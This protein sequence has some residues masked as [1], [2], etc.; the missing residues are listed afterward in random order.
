MSKL[1]GNMRLSRESVHFR[2]LGWS[3]Q[4]PWSRLSPTKKRTSF[5]PSFI[6][7]IQTRSDHASDHLLSDQLV[8]SVQPSLPDTQLISEDNRPCA[9]RSWTLVDFLLFWLAM[10]VCIPTFLLSNGLILEGFSATQALLVILVGTLLTLIPMIA[11]AHPGTKYGA[12]F[13]GVR[14]NPSPK[15]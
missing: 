10:V 2:C 5:S 8:E 14:L 1:K 9:E 11:S 13:P 3:L 6:P 12:P 7:P 15:P 4:P